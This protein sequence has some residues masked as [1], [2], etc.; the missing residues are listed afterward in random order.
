MYQPMFPATESSGHKYMS[1][2][3]VLV[4]VGQFCAKSVAIILYRGSTNSA[5]SINV[6]YEK[7]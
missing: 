5:H 3:L 2:L 4:N 1:V 6:S 7:I